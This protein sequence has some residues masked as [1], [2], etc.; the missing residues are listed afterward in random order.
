MLRMEAAC[1]III[2]FIAVNYF[3]AGQKHTKLHKIFSLL[4]I[5]MLIH[6]VLDGATV[7]TV[8]HLSAVPVF[9][10]DILHRLFIG[11]MVLVVFLFYVYI[12]SLVEEETGEKHALSRF[13]ATFFFVMELGV[14][15]LPVSYEITPM[16]N[17]SAGYY[18]DMI[19]ASL[20]YYLV[21]C[22]GIL[23]RNRNKLHPKKKYAI[24]AA[25]LIELCVSVLQKFHPTWLISGMG[26][27]LMTLA[28]Y[29]TLENPDILRSELN[30]Q[31]MSMLYLK[32]QV[33]PHFLYN[34]IDTI[35]IQA[36]LN[37]DKP[38][39]DL[40]MKLVDFFRMSVKTNGQMTALEDEMELIDAYM[41]IMCFRYPEL[42]CEYDIDPD[43][44]SCPVPNFILQ[45][46]V[47]N[48]LLH[49]LKNKGYKGEVRISA[50]K[51]SEK[52]I[53]IQVSD[54]GSGFDDET[55]ARVDDILLHYNLKEQRLEG[56]SI[57]IL[58]VQK[59]IKLLCGKDSGLWYTENKQ[60]GVT[61]HMR[62]RITDGGEGHEK[63]KGIA[64]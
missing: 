37:N 41:E 57:G 44:Y 52:Y 32:S 53:E 58:N 15:L 64:G 27:T 39:A 10:N 2:A 8:N 1:F 49:G 21:L 63:I 36:Q 23:I 62:L 18:V 40:L 7:Y 46:I 16:G 34:T 38:V 42:F 51:T 33:N 20:A 48:S 61:A 5:T 47:E 9:F 24:G 28:F 26:M 11:T 6:L 30:E 14:M 59:R 4:L 60:A 13:S 19:Y 17:Y 50:H 29:F 12:S 45:P 31:K 55:K 35:R 3:S 54:T 25:L 43:I 22:G 56:D